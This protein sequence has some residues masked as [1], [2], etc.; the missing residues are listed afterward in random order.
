MSGSAPERRTLSSRGAILAFAVNLIVFFAI[1]LQVMSVDAIEDTLSIRLFWW[2][3]LLLLEE[4]ELYDLS[5]WGYAIPHIVAPIS[6]FVAMQ[7]VGWF[8][9]LGARQR[10]LIESNLAVGLVASAALG[11]V[12]KQPMGHVWWSNAEGFFSCITPMACFAIVATLWM[13]GFRIGATDPDAP[14][15][16]RFQFSIAAMIVLTTVLGLMLRL[17]A[18][19]EEDFAETMR[20]TTARWAVALGLVISTGGA[21]L[22]FGVPGTLHANRMIERSFGIVAVALALVAILAFA[23][24]P[25]S[26]ANNK[27]TAMYVSMAAV[28][29]IGIALTFRSVWWAIALSTATIAMLSVAYLID[30]KAIDVPEIFWLGDVLAWLYNLGCALLVSLLIAIPWLVAGVRSYAV[31]PVWVRRPQTASESPGGQ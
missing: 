23:G 12:V 9:L 16:T 31:S 25:D 4:L 8:L 13:C 2:K 19:S 24:D 1:Y 5:I 30:S 22:Y 17:V 10:G 29:P 20:W 3:H 26:A 6:C 28:S 11:F 18:S 7:S 15:R 27:V 21:A 14:G